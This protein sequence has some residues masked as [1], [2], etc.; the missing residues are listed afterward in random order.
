[1]NPALFIDGAFSKLPRRALVL[2]FC[3]IWGAVI[4][5]FAASSCSSPSSKISPDIEA[6]YKRLFKY[7]N[8]VG[9]DYSF[10]SIEADVKRQL[11]GEIEGEPPFWIVPQIT[12]LSELRGSCLPNAKGRNLRIRLMRKYGIVGPMILLSKRPSIEHY[13][14]HTDAYAF[15]PAEI[16]AIFGKTPNYSHLAKR[17]ICDPAALK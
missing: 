1:M 3:R 15:T 17:L 13:V 6:D 12:L 9:D 8:Q 11:S 16:E 5:L 7:E 14:C 2:V 4:I 10:S